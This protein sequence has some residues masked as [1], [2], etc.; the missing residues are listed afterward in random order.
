MPVL[1][2][3]CESFDVGKINPEF[4]LWLTSMPCK[5]FPVSI[6]QS[7]VKMTN[8]P[9]KGLKANLRNSYFKLNND[10]LNATRKPFEYKKLLYG[11]LEYPSI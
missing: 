6:L 11:Q 3:I 10:L 2:Q 4:R 8:E 7:A 9:P 1:E 5:E